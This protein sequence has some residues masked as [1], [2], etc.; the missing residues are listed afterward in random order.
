[1]GLRVRPV[2]AVVNT[3]QPSKT[4]PT[5]EFDAYTANYNE[6]INKA[7]NF[8][9]LDIDF[10]ARVK[11]DYLVDILNGRPGGAARAELLDVGCGVANAHKQL[12]GRV[13]KISG[14]DVSAAS[15]A[16]A[17]QRNHG[18]QYDVFDGTHLPFADGSFDVAFAINVFHH[19][20]L[21]L[22][23]V[24]VED[25]R[26]VLRPGGLFAIFEHNPLNPVTRRVVDKCEFD[27]D[28]ILLRRRDSEALLSATGF[29]DIKTRYI[30][31]VPATGRLLRGV[32]RLFSLLP[33]GAQ[34]YTL[35]NRS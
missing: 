16:V 6:E 21:A 24:L 4:P 27:K 23:S 34:Y 18:I 5:S 3:D 1:M 8:S 19:V 7:L 20:P 14:I 10:F 35:G 15:I 28:A 2:E 33:L 12:V 30:F 31:A 17:R 26:R 13:G 29:R 9:G 22:R 11:N 32:D 25:I